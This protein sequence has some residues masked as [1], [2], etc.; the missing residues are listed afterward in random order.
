MSTGDVEGF[1]PG[2]TEGEVFLCLGDAGELTSEELGVEMK[3][4]KQGAARALGHW[5]S[6]SGPLVRKVLHSGTPPKWELVKSAQEY[7]DSL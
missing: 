4:S 3:I 6:Q 7:F 5:A 1:K 2:T